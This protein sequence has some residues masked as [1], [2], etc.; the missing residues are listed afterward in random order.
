[1]KP[2]PFLPSLGLFLTALGNAHLISLRQVSQTLT[3][4]FFTYTNPSCSPSTAANYHFISFTSAN[5][6]QCRNL[7]QVFDSNGAVLGYKAFEIDEFGAGSPALSGSIFF[8][9]GQSCGGQA[10]ESRKLDAVFLGDGREELVGEGIG[11]VVV[12]RA[13]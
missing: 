11:S 2:S 7:E 13:S 5:I 8:Y 1:M 12:R 6:G 4:T 9:K 10:L 3:L